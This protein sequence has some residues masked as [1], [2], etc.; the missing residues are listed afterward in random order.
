MTTAVI[1][2]GNIGTS[3]ARHLAAGGED[4]VVANRTQEKADALA[5]QL[6][7]NVRAAS[8]DEALTAADDVVLAVW[9]DDQQA[10]LAEH[11]DAL[12]GKTIIDPSNPIRFDDQG[13]VSRTL[14]DGVSSGQRNRDALPAGARLAKAFGSISAD[15]LAASSNS[16]PRTV[17][18]YAADDDAA[19]SE[20]ARLITVAGFEPVKLG[21][22]DES[23]R[24]EVLGE[25]HPFGQLD[26]TNP[27]T[28][29][30]E[31]LLAR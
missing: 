18:F 13:N 20:A 1:G 6:G 19:A 22:I 8:V 4:V 26:G 29:N 16:D 7:D 23:I 17:L 27:T 28:E 10:F 9:F 21:G 2:T 3:V 15:D 12:A 30:V 24:M 31:G 5:A 25:L 11:A 14:P